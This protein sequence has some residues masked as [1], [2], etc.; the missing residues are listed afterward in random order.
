MALDLNLIF[1]NPQFQNYKGVLGYSLSQE[2]LKEMENAF[3]SR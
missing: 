2:Q 3:Y 1:T